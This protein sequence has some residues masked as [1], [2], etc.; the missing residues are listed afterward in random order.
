MKELVSP[1]M[2]ERVKHRYR[3]GMN[4]DKQT[5]DA[6]TRSTRILLAE[7][8]TLLHLSRRQLPERGLLHVA[9]AFATK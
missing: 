8:W 1:G 4:H 3:T 2:G 9:L 6:N 5:I 7:F